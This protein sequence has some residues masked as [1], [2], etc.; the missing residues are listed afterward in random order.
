[1]YKGASDTRLVN[2]GLVHFLDHILE[3]NPNIEDS[4]LVHAL[5]ISYLDNTPIQ[6]QISD[7]VTLGEGLFTEDDLRGVNT[8]CLYEITAPN[9]IRALHDGRTRIDVLTQMDVAELR[10]ASATNE[11]PAAP[12][13][14]M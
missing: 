7:A 9:A 11:Y 13:P 1:M 6:Q 3:S 5:R 8:E 12:Q 10:N 14:N 4:D 2:W